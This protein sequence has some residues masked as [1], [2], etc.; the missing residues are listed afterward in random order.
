MSNIQEVMQ[1]YNNAVKLLNSS[2]QDSAVEAYT[3]LGCLGRTPETDTYRTNALSKLN[4]IGRA[5]FVI[6]GVQAFVTKAQL[7]STSFKTSFGGLRT[8]FALPAKGVHYIVAVDIT[9]DV[10]CGVVATQWITRQ[11]VSVKNIPSL[12]SGNS[13]TLRESALSG[14]YFEKYSEINAVTSGVRRTPD[15]MEK[16]V[17]SRMADKLRQMR[18]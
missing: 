3:V 12:L 4:P 10:N 1:Q 13:P 7:Q 8:M 11:P 16:A 15:A 2:G 18:A 6:S 14:D 5:W 17:I 9:V